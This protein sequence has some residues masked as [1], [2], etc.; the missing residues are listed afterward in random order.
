M[1]E[2]LG[3]HCHPVS[4]ML[5]QPW[6]IQTFLYLQVLDFLTTL[7]GFRLGASEASPFIAKLIHLASPAAG[8]A[9]SKLIGI[10]IGLVCVTTNRV[11]LIEWMNYWYAAL[12]VWNLGII[13]VILAGLGH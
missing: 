5:R 1:R 4:G 8:V 7:I 12:V 2:T 9:A 11:R 6:V 3:T 13:F 10:G